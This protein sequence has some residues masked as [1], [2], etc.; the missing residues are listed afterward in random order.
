[1]TLP[2]PPLPTA[3]AQLPAVPLAGRRLHRVFRV[4]RSSP[5]W[6]ASLPVGEYD[7]DM[8]GRFDLP[9]PGGACYLASSAVAAVL[10]AVVGFDRLADVD[11]RARR[12]AEVVAPPTSNRTSL[13]PP[14]PIRR[15]ARGGMDS[16]IRRSAG[17]GHV[18]PRRAAA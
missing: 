12:R 5:W 1:V 4:G 15:P 2:D 8:H 3:L 13:R 7:P 16:R 10:E 18:R 9:A 11:L 17:R 6:F 14:S